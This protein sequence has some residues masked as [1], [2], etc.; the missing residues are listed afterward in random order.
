MF[1]G[2]NV[3]PRVASG[4][5]VGKDG[6]VVFGTAVR[7][8]GAMVMCGIDV[9]PNNGSSG[10]VGGGTGGITVGGSESGV[11]VG[12][13]RTDPVGES[14]PGKDGTFVGGTK[15][16]VSVVG[17]MVDVSVVGTKV[18]VSVVGTK[19]GVSVVGISVAA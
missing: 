18:G 7:L 6:A 10:N 17:T 5:T 11:A 8:D 12:P 4:A 13:S 3:G 1:C 15:V 16:G 14:V 9:G 2:K 19:V